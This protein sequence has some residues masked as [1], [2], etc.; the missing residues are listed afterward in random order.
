MLCGWELTETREQSKDYFDWIDIISQSPVLFP[1]W[2]EYRIYKYVQMYSVDW[3]E[4]NECTEASINHNRYVISIEPI[5]KH[6]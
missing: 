2:R 1:L 3:C 5:V 6:S 4:W